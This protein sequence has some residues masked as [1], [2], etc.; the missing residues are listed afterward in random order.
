LGL[1][2]KLFGGKAATDA[3]RVT[4]Y[5]RALTAYTPSFMSR[6]GGLYEMELTRSAI[7]AF[8]SHV[9]KLK[10]EVSGAAK[11][12]LA[13]LLQY[14][15]NK[16]MD[17]SKFLYR[18]ATILSVTTTAFIVP[19]TDA[20]DSVITGFYPL[21][22]GRAEIMEFAGEPWLRYT[23]ANG[24]RAAI[25]FTRV[26]ILTTHQYRDDFFGDGHD[27]LSPTLDLLDVQRQAMTEAVTSSAAIRFFARLA[28]TLRPE[29]IK[30]ERDRFT[31]DN[32]SADN[33]SGVMMFDAKYADV[34]QIDSKQF[35]ID[36]DQMKLIKDN[37]FGYFGANDAIL[38]NSY[39]ENGWN[40]FYEGKVEPFALQLGLVMTNMVY[41]ARE[42]SF[43]N[44]VMFS[45]NRLQY[46][47]NTSK[48]A[49]TTQ[50]MDRGLLS[51]YGAA[52]IWNLPQPDGPE[53]WVIRGEYIDI[54]NLPGHTVDQAKA[55]AAAA[56]AAATAPVPD[57]TIPQ[58]T[59]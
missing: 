2:D 25:E 20:T 21:L 45:S 46:A 33:K 27:A 42:R 10:P 1:F 47:S 7:H 6:T 29:D 28:G 9:S 31:L 38:T 49:V 39:D 11:S 8:A 50:L 13:P 59:P 54:S 43:G 40:A 36:A 41:T 35:V 12:S 4:S 19:L 58:A 48:L 55:A 52:D 56:L 26:G 37:V 34:K 14:Q 53:R 24:Q 15:P 5:F 57:T 16:F 32:L 22:P 51:N 23:F 44:Q 18:L 3:D 17:T 30:A